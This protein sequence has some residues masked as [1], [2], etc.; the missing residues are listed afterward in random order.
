MVNVAMSPEKYKEFQEA[1][2]RDPVLNCVKRYVLEGWPDNQVE[3]PLERW[4]FKEDIS[5]KDGLLFKS[6][7]VIGDVKSYTQVSLGH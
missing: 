3:C 6:D 2:S 5:Y 7:K 1:T 4:T